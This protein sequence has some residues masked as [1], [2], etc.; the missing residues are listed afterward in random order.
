MLKHWDICMYIGYQ[1]SVFWYLME[2]RVGFRFISL[3]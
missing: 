1:Q 2:E 3:L